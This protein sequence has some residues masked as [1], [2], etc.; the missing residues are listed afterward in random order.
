MTALQTNLATIAS[1]ITVI[2]QAQAGQ[3]TV[4][5]RSDKIFSSLNLQNIFIQGN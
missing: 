1:V 2:E 5:I 4:V 3:L